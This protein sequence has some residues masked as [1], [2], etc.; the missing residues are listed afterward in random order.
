[1]TAATNYEGVLSSLLEA[2]FTYSGYLLKV[3]PI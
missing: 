3:I 2:S 1:M